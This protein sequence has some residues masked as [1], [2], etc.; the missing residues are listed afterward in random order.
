MGGLLHHPR[1]FSDSHEFPG[2]DEVPEKVSR[3]TMNK[4]AGCP[5]LLSQSFHTFSRPGLN[6]LRN[7]LAQKPPWTAPWHT[8]TD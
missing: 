2:D 5:H 7:G 8:W 3:S 6:G 4:R 1:R